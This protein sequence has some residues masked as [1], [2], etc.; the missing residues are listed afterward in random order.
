MPIDPLTGAIVATAY[1]LGAVPFGLVV[2]R[3]AGLG[4][5]RQIGSGNIGATNVLR[6]GHKF[7]AALTLTLDMAKGAVAVILAWWLAPEAV[8]FAG[9]A[10]FLGH[11]YPV[12]LT[13]KGGK[14]VATYL[15]VLVAAA[16]PVGLATG[17]TWL[18]AAAIGRI[19]SLS[20][21]IAA[22]L[23][24]I[25]AFFLSG[26]AAALLTLFMAVLIFLK[27]KD[28]IVRLRRGTEPRI[29]GF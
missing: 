18:A 22:S 7:L 5:I 3:L 20:A 19:S 23:S 28:N 13:F 26:Q 10:A 6:T 4:D 27:H 24:P 9:A 16:W 12:W 14:G 11:L 15:G 8:P 17:A 2:T 29:G 21:L 1:L 25:Y